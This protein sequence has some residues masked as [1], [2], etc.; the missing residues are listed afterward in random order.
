V[1]R[2]DVDPYDD[3][4]RTEIQLVADLMVA[5]NECNGSLCQADIDALLGLRRGLDTAGSSS[6][7]GSGSADAS[8]PVSAN[9]SVL[10]R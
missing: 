9:D 2:L 10:S 6:A 1:D 3:E 5:A 8:G 4:L 7:D